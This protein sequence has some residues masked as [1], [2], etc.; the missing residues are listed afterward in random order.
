MCGRLHKEIAQKGIKYNS[1]QKFSNT[2]DT[3]RYEQTCRKN[4]PT[5]RFTITLKYARLSVIFVC[6]ENQMFNDYYEDHGDGRG[7]AV[8]SLNDHGENDDDHDDDHGDKY[9]QRSGQQA[10][11]N[12]GNPTTITRTRSRIQIDDPA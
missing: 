5:W 1:V 3:K 9:V 2:K 6:S 10:P 8:Q 11:H 7:G 12:R 4:Y